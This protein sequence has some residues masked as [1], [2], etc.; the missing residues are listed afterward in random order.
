MERCEHF[1]CPCCH[2]D[3]CTGDKAYFEQLNLCIKE[4]AGSEE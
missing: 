3:Y 1:E 4:N 2:W